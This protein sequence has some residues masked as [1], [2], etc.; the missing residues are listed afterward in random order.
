ML[1]NYRFVVLN[2]HDYIDLSL[3]RESRES[4][5]LQML[6][7]TQKHNDLAQHSLYVQNDNNLTETLSAR[8]GRQK[9]GTSH[10][11]VEL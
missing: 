1:L 6:E 7:N 11:G 4:G 9:I 2:A 3:M 8:T 5:I 10:I